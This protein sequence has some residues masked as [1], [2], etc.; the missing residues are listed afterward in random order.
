[1]S[2]KKLTKMNEIKNK[3]KLD[4]DENELRNRNN[5]YMIN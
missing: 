1:M 5:I 3:I 2:M 4:Y